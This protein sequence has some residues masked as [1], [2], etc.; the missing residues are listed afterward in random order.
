MGFFAPSGILNRKGFFGGISQIQPSSNK[1]AW[2][3]ADAGTTVD[4]NDRLTSWADQSGSGNDATPYDSGYEPLLSANEINGLEA[5]FF[6][7]NFDDVMARLLVTPS[8]LP[9]NY[10]TPFSVIGVIKANYDD[11]VSNDSQRWLL[12]AGITEDWL[13]GFDF[14]PYGGDKYFSIMYGSNFVGELGIA[15]TQ[16]TEGT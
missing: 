16:L 2:Y 6:D 5:I 8:I 14:G 4:G 12:Q 3:K 11:I 1:I 15:G 7:P 10:N 9:T 13:C